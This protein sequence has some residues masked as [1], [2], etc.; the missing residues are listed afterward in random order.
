MEAEDFLVFGYSCKVLITQKLF[1]KYIITNIEKFDALRPYH[2]YRQQID[3]PYQ[4][5]ILSYQF[6]L[7]GHKHNNLLYKYYF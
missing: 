6:L 5:L 7:E 4:K 2:Y 1:P 3:L